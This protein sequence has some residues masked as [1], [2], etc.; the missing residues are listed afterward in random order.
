LPA[1]ELYVGLMSGTSADAIDAALVRFTPAPT[2]VAAQTTPLPAAIR[3]QIRRISA[4][5]PLRVLGQLD[6]QLGR[7]F[8]AAAQD[9]LRS[10]NQEAAT[11]RAIGSHG[12]TVWHEP[13]G[14]FPFSMQIGDPSII[15]EQTGITT[16]ADFRRRDMAAG[17]Q[18][19]PLVPAFHRE[20]FGVSE[21]IR[22]VLNLGGIANITVL[23]PGET[24]GFDTGPANTLLDGWAQQHLGQPFDAGGQWAAGGEPQAWLMEA[25]LEDAYFAKAAP[26]STGPE[27]FSPQW[28][29]GH[30]DKGPALRPQDVQAT[31]LELS[32][33][34]V[35]LAVHR[36]AA[37]ADT[38]L[39]C[40][41][42]VHN[43]RLMGRLAELL[44][45]MPV[46]STAA[47]GID[48]DYVEACAFAWLAR[49]RLLG[50]A[51]NLPAATGAR[52]PVVLGGIYF[53]K[54]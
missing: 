29:R 47:A 10:A 8:A 4:D 17:G 39:V 2:V 3:Q 1:G 38:L 24:L 34:S 18:G 14:D 46:A 41:G 7:L 53:G 30:L 42:G 45:P 13:A 12:Q 5:T 50:E 40:G 20:I 28:L 11:V 21:K 6:A 35:A 27:H 9:L 36:Y 48:P 43:R 26:K 52:A 16:V 49:Q 54:S 37:T 15:A 32:A 19:A 51:G 31:L 44:A 22:C 23:Q 25:L 33:R